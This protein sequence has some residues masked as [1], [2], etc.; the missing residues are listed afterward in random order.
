MFVETSGLPT[1][2]R[3]RRF[4]LKN[5]YEREATLRDYYRDGDDLVVFRKRLA[6]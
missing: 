1:Y 5:G 3:T 2:E 6:P 4:Y